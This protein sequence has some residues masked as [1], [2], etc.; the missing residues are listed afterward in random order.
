MGKG[1]GVNWRRTDCTGRRSSGNAA[2]HYFGR[3][4]RRWVSMPMVRFAG[5][6][7]RSAIAE[8]LVAA[9]ILPVLGSF[10]G[11]SVT[12]VRFN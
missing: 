3:T 6:A 2:E 8:L 11:G 9:V 10:I 12:I 1:S 4:S 7:R 5:E